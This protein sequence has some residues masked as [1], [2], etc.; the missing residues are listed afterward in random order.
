MSKFSPDDDLYRTEAQDGVRRQAQHA[1]FIAAAFDCSTKTR[2]REIATGLGRSPQALRSE[3]FPE[4][5]SGLRPAA[6]EIIKADNA[7][8]HKVLAVMRRPMD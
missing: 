3:D 6:Q 2:A 7:A 4:G 1:D 8:C 5:L